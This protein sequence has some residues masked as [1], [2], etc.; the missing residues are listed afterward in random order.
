MNAI[1]FI[2]AFYFTTYWNVF[3]LILTWAV[4]LYYIGSG[5]QKILR[6][7]EGSPSQ[8]FAVFFAIAITFFIGLRPM[9]KDF[10]D[11][12]MY[13]WAYD[14][15]TGVFEMPSLSAEWL[16]NDSMTLFKVLGFNIHEFFLFVAFVYI[17]GMLVSGVLV[18]RRNLFMCMMFM[19]TS[20]SFFSFGSNGIR[21]G[22]SC[23]I[24]MVAICLLAREPEKKVLPIFLMALA[25]GVHRS[26]MLPIASCFAAIYFI[27]DPKIALRFWLISIVISLVAGPFVEQFFAALGFD[28]RMTKYTTTSEEFKSEA[29]SQT[30]FRWDFLLYSAFPV[31]MVWYV[32]V[33]R[34]F[35]DQTFNIIAITYL[36]SNAFW[37]MVIRAAFSNRFAYLSWFIYPLVMAYPLLRMNLWED[38]DRKTSLILFAYSGFLFFMFFIYY[39]GTT[40]FKG[41]DLYWWRKA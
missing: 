1:S 38:Q 39:F 17:M 37:I 2:D 21:S 31:L 9:Y 27:K 29:F 7:D 35:N 34:K 16:W 22:M 30:G 40:G 10:T 19:I 33:H 14:H 36:L 32:T 13:A 5:G 6:M 25:M 20:F 15:N 26:T 12:K 23:S 24:A 11:M 3:L 4:V 41:F 18:T 28:D 8:G